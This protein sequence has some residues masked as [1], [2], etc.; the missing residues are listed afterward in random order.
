[1][2]RKRGGNGGIL[3]REGRCEGLRKEGEKKRAKGEREREACMYSLKGGERRRGNGWRRGR[4]EGR[5]GEERG[6]MEGKCVYAAEQRGSEG[7]GTRGEKYDIK[8]EGRVKAANLIHEKKVEK[9]K[10]KQMER[11]ENNDRKIIEQK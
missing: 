5:G 2:K 6:E 9:K 11:I 3:E 7:K 1:M 8:Q 10:S 4:Y